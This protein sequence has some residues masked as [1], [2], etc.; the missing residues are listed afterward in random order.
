M[1]KMIKH[2][3]IDFDRA[4]GINSIFIYVPISELENKVEELGK[5][6]R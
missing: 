4:E 3:E 5:C 2:E 1:I 6:Q